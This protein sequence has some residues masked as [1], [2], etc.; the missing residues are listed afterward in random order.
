MR[1]LIFSASH[2]SPL[3]SHESIG[4]VPRRQPR[5]VI[6]LEA[7]RRER[8]H[9]VGQLQAVDRRRLRPANFFHRCHDPE[10]SGRL[11]PPGEQIEQCLGSD[12]ALLPSHDRV[13][14]LLGGTN[15]APRNNGDGLVFDSTERLREAAR[16]IDEQ[17]VPSAF[18]R[19]SPR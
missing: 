16:G 8:L 12:A 19:E 14:L 2:V 9:E 6:L 10:L 4:H 18:Q 11:E 17:D 7:V 5:F 15:R 3:T 13:E 1:S